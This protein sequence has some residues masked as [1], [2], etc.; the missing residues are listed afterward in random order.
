[1]I[2]IAAFRGSCEIM[3]I[4]LEK[5]KINEIPINATDV[6]GDDPVNLACIRGFD[7]RVD[8][9]VFDE[10]IG[11]YVSRRFKVAKLL[12][13]YRAKDG[14]NELVIRYDKL[15]KGLNS[16]LHWAIY[17]TDIDL[18]DYVYQECREQIFWMNQDGM[19][20]FDMCYQTETKFSENKAKMVRN[21]F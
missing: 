16:P 6:N 7:E 10:E 15:R 14:T 2:H 19:I 5:S 20:P 18:A 3:E 4:L 13:D 21:F 1:M 11:R 9:Q 8:E 12:L 17:W